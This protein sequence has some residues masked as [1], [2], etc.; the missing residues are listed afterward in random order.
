M[1]LKSQDIRKETIDLDEQ[2]KNEG[3]EENERHWGCS[4][5]LG[6]IS[7]TCLSSIGSSIGFRMG[8]ANKIKN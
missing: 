2:R 3:G 7:H 5:K 6:E 1:G 8:R 4:E